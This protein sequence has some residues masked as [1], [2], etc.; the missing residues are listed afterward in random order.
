MDE[1]DIDYFTFMGKKGQRLTFTAHARSLRSPLDPV[2][3]VYFGEGKEFKNLKGSDDV[4][5]NPDS[6]F[7]LTLPADGKYYV[8]ITDHLRKGGPDYSTAQKP[9]PCAQT[10]HSFHAMATTI[11]SLVR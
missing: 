8:R 5:R 6:K 11:P 9:K 10:R 2:L 7:D 1:E 4:G 3:N